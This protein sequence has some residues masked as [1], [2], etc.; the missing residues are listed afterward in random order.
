MKHL[1]PV[2]RAIAL[3]TLTVAVGACGGASNSET[4]TQPDTSDVSTS[5]STS[6]EPADSSAIR[7]LDTALV[8]E[9][10]AAGG[11]FHTLSV[12]LEN[13][14]DQV[15]LDVTG[16]VSIRQR[17]ELIQSV[18]PIPVNILQGERGIWTELLDLPMPVKDGELEIA[19]SVGRFAPGP[20]ESP[21]SFSKLRYRSGGLFAC[22]VSGT[23]SNTFTEQKTDLQLRVGWYE[24][25]HLISTGFTYI[26]TVFPSADATFEVTGIGEAECPDDVTT[27]LATANL[28][29]DKLFNP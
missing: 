5:T 29:E 17:G 1:I 15:A 6:M 26:D 2:N 12:V 25:D 14:S 18:N 21:V 10:E 7:V 8:Y 16:Q 13:T 20:A 4:G 23:V 19:V 22:S 28:G 3:M 24:G 27:I 11:N 9:P